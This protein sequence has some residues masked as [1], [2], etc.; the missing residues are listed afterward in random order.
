MK[1]SEADQLNGFYGVQHLVLA[2]TVTEWWELFLHEALQRLQ[3]PRVHHLQGR[4]LWAR[5]GPQNNGVR[6]SQFITCLQGS[7]Q[8]SAGQVPGASSIV[9]R[10]ANTAMLFLEVS[11]HIQQMPAANITFLPVSTSWDHDISIY[12]FVNVGYRRTSQTATACPSL[13]V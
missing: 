4:V 10:A 13:L 6:H 1:I 12:L 5:A 2:V 11:H 8:V 9:G 7:Y 3:W